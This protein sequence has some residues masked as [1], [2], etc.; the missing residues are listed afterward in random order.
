MRHKPKPPRFVRQRQ[1]AT[2][3]RVLHRMA[4]NFLFA[5]AV[6]LF[7]YGRISGLALTLL[8]L[9]GTEIA[10]HYCTRTA[11]LQP[12]PDIRA[13]EGSGHGLCCSDLI[14]IKE[15]CGH[16][17]S[18]KVG[19]AGPKVCLCCCEKWLRYTGIDLDRLRPYPL[20]PSCPIRHRHEL[21]C[22][23]LPRP[24]LLAHLSQP[25]ARVFFD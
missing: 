17:A 16:A 21:A 9:V 7:S 25:G 24:H 15:S 23:V 10:W 22:L 14:Y 2:R 3:W 5:L 4:R 12:I 1:R 20:E 19:E 13:L 18:Y 11:P 6:C 8:A